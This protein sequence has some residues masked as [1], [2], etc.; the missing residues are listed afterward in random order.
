MTNE[1]NNAFN[2][3]IRGYDIRGVF[4]KDLTPDLIEKI[5]EAFG[6]EWNG[7]KIV[8]GMDNR[9]HS[10]EVLDSFLRGLQLF[11]VEI[12]DC[13]LTTSP[14]ISFIAKEKDCFGVMITAS[15]NNISYNGIKL[16]KPNIQ[17]YDGVEIKNIVLKR[18]SSDNSAKYKN[19]TIVIQKLDA[20]SLYINFWLSYMGFLTLH[21]GIHYYF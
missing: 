17:S 19:N 8:I 14:V 15:H 6:S 3:I 7:K 12:F 4:G 5:G 16:C 11:D 20:N 2:K 13:G 9:P 1:L 10:K 21:F 18:F